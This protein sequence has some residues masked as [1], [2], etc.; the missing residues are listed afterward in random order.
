MN[1]ARELIQ[2]QDEGNGAAWRV[3]PVIDFTV[4]GSLDQGAE[5]LTH[6]CIEFLSALKPA[7]GIADSALEPIID[8]TKPESMNFVCTEHFCS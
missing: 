1:V 4:S 8:L 7:L 2:R 5:L 6:G 3:H